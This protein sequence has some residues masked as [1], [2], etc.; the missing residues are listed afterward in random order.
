MLNCK[1]VARL[2]ASEELADAGWLN[3]A[4][5]RL[6]LLRCRDCAGYAAQLRAIG[7]AARDRWDLSE[8]DRAALEKLESSIMERCLDALDVNSEDGR[9]RAAE[10]PATP[11]RIEP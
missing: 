3:R 11:K 1:E 8:A 5:I 7:I 6:Y 2:M 9:G 4:L 10:P